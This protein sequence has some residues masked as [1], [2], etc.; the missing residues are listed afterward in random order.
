[1]AA[2]ELENQERCNNRVQFSEMDT[3]AFQIK[4]RCVCR[5]EDRWKFLR[6]R[7]NPDGLRSIFL[8]SAS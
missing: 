3:G 7:Y 5:A 4:K 8:F 1:M 2:T 6:V